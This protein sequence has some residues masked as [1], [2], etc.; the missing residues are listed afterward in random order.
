MNLA[1]SSYYEEP[2]A[3]PI[4]DAVIVERIGDICAEFPRYGYRRVTAQL[5]RDGLRVNHKKAM[6][7]MREQDLTVRPRRRFVATTDS[8]HDGPIF[9]NLAKGLL[10]IAPNEL[11]VADITYIAIATGFV[12]L[13][14]ILDAWSRRVVGYAIGRSIDVRLTLAALRAAIEVRR[15]PPGCIHHSDRGSQGGFKWSSQHLEGG[16]CDEEAQAA[17]GSVWSGA[18]VLTRSTAG[19]RAR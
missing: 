10:P 6:R 9:P 14:V 16:G 7:L 13:A 17:F 11:W 18:I 4:G 8:N 1:R 3:Q 12:Y 19:G 15:P 5:R 2:A